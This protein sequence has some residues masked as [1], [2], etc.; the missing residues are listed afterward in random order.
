M[1]QQADPQV[2]GAVWP[3]AE[4]IELTRHSTVWRPSVLED[5]LA[6]PLDLAKLNAAYNVV[7]L[8]DP[9]YKNV[10]NASFLITMLTFTGVLVW[11]G[12]VS[13]WR[14]TDSRG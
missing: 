7:S 9:L 14:K 4:G 3:G 12:W 11:W 10:V 2:T 8:V 1:D 5:A 13:L 6:Q